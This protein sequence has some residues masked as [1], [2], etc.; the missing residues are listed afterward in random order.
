[1]NY[2]Y[3]RLLG[4]SPSSFSASSAARSLSK[5]TNISV[6]RKAAC[7]KRH[8]VT[9]IGGRVRNRGSTGRAAVRVALEVNGVRQPSQKVD[10]SARSSAELVTLLQSQE[11]WAQ[12]LSVISDALAVASLLTAILPEYLR[13]LWILGGVSPALVAQV[14]IILALLNRNHEVLAHHSR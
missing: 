9:E 11:E 5:K 7:S 13:N 14:A 6:P 2:G 4:F 3:C 1:M 12:S 8:I 10:L